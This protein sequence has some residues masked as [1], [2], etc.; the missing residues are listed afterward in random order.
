MKTIL[1]RFR[2]SPAMVIACIALELR[3]GN[4]RGRDS[5]LAKEQCRHEA[6]QEER[7][8]L[9]Q[10]QEQL[11][12]GRGLQGRAAPAGPTRSTGTHHGRTRS[13]QACARSSD[14]CL[15]AG[16]RDRCGRRRQSSKGID[17]CERHPPSA[18][19]AYCIAGLAFTPLNPMAT[20]ESPLAAPDLVI[21]TRRRRWPFGCAAADASARLHRH[22]G[23]RADR[24]HLLPSAQL[25]R[26]DR[27]GSARRD[28]PTRAC[29]SL[30]C[31]AAPHE[32]RPIHSSPPS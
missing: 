23:R 22:R 8:H 10:G 30:S 6:A 15:R 19:G 2:P 12:P 26:S 29:P 1:R 24:Q 11:A 32:P 31:R 17:D 9:D 3:S 28:E 25:M 4:E 7:S 27:P 14:A 5:S 16:A 13:Y 21:R 18:A 20:L